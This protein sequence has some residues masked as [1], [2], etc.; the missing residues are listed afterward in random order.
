MAPELVERVRAIMPGIP[1]RSFN[2]FSTLI[3]LVALY[4]LL[5]GAYRL[6]LS[7]AAKFPGPKLA[8]LTF[9]Y[10]FY[11]DVWREGQYTWKI[12]DLHRQY[13]MCL[14]S[15]AIKK[16]F[17]ANSDG[18][19]P[20]VRINPLEVHCDDLDFLDVL[21]V[22]SAKRRSDK[23]EWFIRQSYETLFLCLDP[24]FLVTYP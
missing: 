20:F 3:V 18:E 24:Y 12:R 2:L 8:A 10:E 9:W 4:P 11:H 13:G 7:P 1:L 23:S 21:Y 15:I 16:V 14:R 6:Y 19:G 22:N 17:T 5:L